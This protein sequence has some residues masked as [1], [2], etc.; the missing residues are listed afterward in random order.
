M[1]GTIFINY[2]REDSIG[3]AGRL[4]DRLALTFG[5]KNLFMDVDS[6]PAGVD[7]L[8][9][10]N[11]QVAACDVVL[12]VIGQNWLDSKDESG[13]R[14]LDNPDDFV[15][16]EIAAALARDIRVIPVLVDE[17]R[18]PKADKL[19]DPIKLLARRNAVE[20]RHT[21][22][23]RDA[24]ALIE[25][26]RS[27]F[28]GGSVE[29]RSWRM[30]AMVLAGAAV[31]VVLLVGW[32]GYSW[33]SETQPT[34][35]IGPVP[36]T[37]ATVTAKPQVDERLAAENERKRVEGEARARYSALLNQG[38]TDA[39]INANDKAI[40]TFSEAIRLNPGAPAAFYE[41]GVVY[42]NK[43]NYD[44]AIADYNE[45]IRLDPGNTSAFSERCFAYRSISEYDK[46]IADCNKA[47]RLDPNNASAFTDR[48]VAFT[49]EADHKRA[50]TD[51]DKAVSVDPKYAGAFLY[52]GL[53]FTRK[54]NLDQATAD[55]NEAIRLVNEAIQSDSNNARALVIRCVAYGDKGDSDR[56]IADCNE[57]IRLN[58]EYAIA[59]IDRGVV[60]E[61][62]GDTDRAITNYNEAIRLNPNAANALVN[63]GIAYSKKGD[64]DRATDYNKAIRLNPKESSPY[65]NR[66]VAYARKG[67]NDRAIADYGEAIMRNPKFALAFCNRGRAKLKINDASC[68]EDIAQARQLN[69][70]VCP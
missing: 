61:R 65:L 32:I 3:T 14:R 50:M 4:R 23:G 12:V 11:K 20:V 39:K 51:Y 19:P 8:T 62:K 38:T 59:F 30:M 56:A 43:S 64:Q 44:K 7:F 40:A 70:S 53:A 13:R 28:D 24:E 18:M 68:N 69:A 9:Y 16:V 67:D 48:G 63:R 55:Y 54:G 29:S 47:I 46:A 2:R 27:A 58:P 21:H 66:G 5:H 26:I 34:A 57:A 22:F 37:I 60:Y 41:R 15:A 6:I 49:R 45:A 42:R 35:S 52:R 31:P 10:L 36:D 17:A 25:K 33:M 1:A